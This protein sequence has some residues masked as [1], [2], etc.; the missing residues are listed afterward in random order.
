MTPNSPKTYV[1]QH[2]LILYFCLRDPKAD[3]FLALTVS[4]QNLN[5]PVQFLLKINF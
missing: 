3:F 1:S 5:R 4:E 2:S